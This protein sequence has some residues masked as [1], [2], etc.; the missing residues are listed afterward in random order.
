MKQRLSRVWRVG[1]ALSL[2]PFVS[3][4]PKTP[5]AVSEKVGGPEPQIEPEPA[6]VFHPVPEGENPADPVAESPV[7]EAAVTRISTEKPLPPDIDPNSPLAE[8]LKLADSGV[9]ESVL[10]AYVSGATAEFELDP[11]AIIF[12]NDIG[13]PPQVVAGMIEHDRILRETAATAVAASPMPEEVAP[14]EPVVASAPSYSVLP[15][16]TAPA[17][18]AIPVSYNTGSYV[19]AQPYEESGESVSYFYDSL[20]PYGSWVDVDGYGRC[21]QPTVVVLNPGWRPYCDRGSWVYTDCGWYWVSEYSWGWAP[22]HYGRWF[23]HARL[24]WC[25]SPDNVWG[26]SWVSWRYS[27]DHCGWAPL[28]PRACYTSSGFTY[29]G[30]PVSFSFNFGL[31]ADCYTFIPLNRFHEKHIS[32]HALA[33]DQVERVMNRTTVTTR[34]IAGAGHRVIN[35]GIAP[36]RVAAVTRREVTRATIREATSND[37]TTRPDRLEADGRILTVH[38]LPTKPAR[39]P[40]PGTRHAS[41]RN[42]TD[43]ETALGSPVSPTV[44][45]AP[46]PPARITRTSRQPRAEHLGNS[47][48]PEADSLVMSRGIPRKAQPLTEASGPAAVVAP[49]ESNPSAPPAQPEVASTPLTLSERIRQLQR[50]PSRATVQPSAPETVEAS[51]QALIIRGRRDARQQAQTASGEWSWQPVPANPLAAPNQ[52]APAAAPR[53]TPRSAANHSPAAVQASSPSEPASSAEVTANARWERQR[54]NV[55]RRVAVDGNPGWNVPVPRSE[56]AHSAA[57]RTSS[58]WQTPTHTPRAEPAQ[59][60]V[61]APPPEPPP[62]VHVAPTPPP[63]AQPA[64]R[65]SRQER[66]ERQERSEARQESGPSGRSRR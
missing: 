8:V 10:L 61:A 65:E 12:L 62:Q 1:L 51:S 60:R 52:S 22:F 43:V 44:P 47:A 3:G 18:E 11:D 13:I 24:G 59:V 64:V 56:A 6:L 17:D 48:S 25:W 39:R 30:R 41:L 58:G 50:V 28:P 29:Y 7:S 49:T 34:I 23:R 36:E 16:S 53:R 33:R 5:T 4:C 45:A 54:A 20:A 15:E 57:P 9:E 63:Q 66:H 55:E 32:R 42:P 40:A 38:R 31:G 27:D 35:Q 2:L 26:P 19:P 46:A 21:W 37:G 14:A